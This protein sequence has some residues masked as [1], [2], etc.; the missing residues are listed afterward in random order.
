M[1]GRSSRFFN[2]GYALPKYQL[3]LNG[4]SVFYHAV[5]SF[6]GYFKTDFFLFVIRSDFDSMNFINN[7]ILKL[8]IH[9]FQIV[10]LDFETDGQAHTC[11][12]GI[13]QSKKSD[14][15]DLYIFNIDTFR[16]DFVKPQ[17]EKKCDGFLEVFLGDGDGWSFIEP[18]ENYSVLRTTEKDRISDFCSDGLYFFNRLSLFNSAYLEARASGSTVKGEYYVAPLYNNLI[19]N[20]LNVCYQLIDSSQVIF[21]GTPNEY[22]SLGGTAPNKE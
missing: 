20:G 2:E 16:P 15:E 7:E 18:G 8:G 22:I 11:Y 19:K 3:D 1:V 4:H 12:E 17:L 10:V 6:R 5:N 13:M 21:C 9:A 14:D